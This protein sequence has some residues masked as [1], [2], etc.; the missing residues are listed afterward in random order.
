M[1][2]QFITFEGGEGAGKTTQAKMLADALESVGIEVILTREPGGTFG[3]ESIRKL[4]LEGT[5]D[6][7][8]G[9]TE[10]LLMYAARIDHVEKLIKPALERG[11]WVISDRFSD[12]SL[13]YQGYARGMGV[14]TVRSVHEVVMQGF[15]PD[16]TLVFDMDVYLSLK[17]VETR[18]FEQDEDLSRFDKAGQNFHIKI[19]D[20]FLDIA[21]TEPD[22]V[23]VIDADGSRAAVHARI[24]NALTAR[25]PQYA[26][27]L[28]GA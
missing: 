2:G 16:L 4:V 17:R 7:W 10:L 1:N 20:A 12:S 28:G 14:E 27:K 13:A 6:R 15:N 24:L 11:A 8:S 3:A 26:G 5:D 19:R 21:R 18:A 25:Y 22:R 23:K 9:M